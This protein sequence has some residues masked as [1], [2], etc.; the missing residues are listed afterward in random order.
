MV[1]PGTATRYLTVPLRGATRRAT[2]TVCQRVSR[3]MR[4]Y[5]LVD[6]LPDDV[7]QVGTWLKERP[8]VAAVHA[9]HFGHFNWLAEIEAPNHLQVQMFVANKVRHHKGVEMVREV[10]QE[11]LAAIL[12]SEERPPAAGRPTDRARGAGSL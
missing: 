8:E 12:A 2:Y 1:S 7:Q 11:Q 5:L 4:A 3:P 9:V 10:E 6:A